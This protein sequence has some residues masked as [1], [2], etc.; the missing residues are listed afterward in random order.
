MAQVHNW[1]EHMVV[2]ETFTFCAH[3]DLACIVW[4]VGF[5]ISISTVAVSPDTH[6]A[7]CFSLTVSLICLSLAS[8]GLY[9]KG[10]FV[11]A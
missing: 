7:I 1:E 3:E 9:K 5:H 6:N 2:D 4:D 8:K 11:S 10:L